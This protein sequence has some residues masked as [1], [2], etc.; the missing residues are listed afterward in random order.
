[1]NKFKN[2]LKTNFF[3]ITILF[4]ILLLGTLL[5]LSVFDYPGPHVLDVQRDILIA[6]HI[7]NQG[8]LTL[9]G[10]PNSFFRSLGNSPFYF[11]LLAIFMTVRNDLMFV[12]TI[13]LIFQVLSILTVYLLGKEIFGKSTG[14]I[15]AFLVSVSNVIVIQASFPY[16][17]HF[18]PPILYL[19][20]LMLVRAYKTKLFYLLIISVGLFLISG[21]IHM[22]AFFLLPL[23]IVV[24]Y[25]ILRKK[26]YKFKNYFLIIS[27]FIFALLFF[28][29]LLSPLNQTSHLFSSINDILPN[30]LIEFIKNFVLLTHKFIN[31]LLHETDFTST[32]DYLVMLLIIAFVL[33]YFLKVKRPQKI[34]AYVIIFELIIYIST[35]A[36]FG[37]DQDKIYRAYVFYAIFPLCLILVAESINQILQHNKFLKLGKYIFLLISLPTLM[38]SSSVLP[39]THKNKD[40]MYKTTHDLKLEIDNLAKNEKDLRFFQ[41]K[42]YECH[43]EICEESVSIFSDALFLIPLEKEF[44]TTFTKIHL[45]NY[46]VLNNDK[47]IFLNCISKNGEPFS[48]QP[49]LGNFLSDSPNYEI[50]KKVSETDNF[51]VY[52]A[53]RRLI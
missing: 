4:L 6:S 31:S 14:I 28:P 20:L 34:Y 25:L 36:L 52:L 19:S 26:S 10:P 16:P 37:N 32:K 40:I 30:S 24:A 7:A 44:K 8:E 45:G 41:I 18:M 9:I 47:Y 33:I 50:L 29:L 27:I 13:N 43:S 46:I 2:L 22:S 12:G 48:E 15:A 35:I 38:G 17:P 11:Y 3:S 21:A 1:M 39:S 42:T 53:K 49:C 23:F 5:R 51:N